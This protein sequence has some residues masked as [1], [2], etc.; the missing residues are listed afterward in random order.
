MRPGRALT[1]FAQT[2]LHTMT[3]WVRLRYR[4]G[5]LNPDGGRM[6]EE[7]FGDIDNRMKDGDYD[8]ERVTGM[9][10]KSVIHDMMRDT[11]RSLLRMKWRRERRRSTKPIFP[12]DLLAKIG[13]SDTWY[14]V[15]EEYGGA[16][17]GYTEHVIAVEELSRASGSVG[18][19]YG[20]H[21]NLCIN[22]LR[23]NGNEVQKQKYLPKLVSGEHVGSLAMSEP[24]AGSDVVSMKLRAEKKGDRYILN[25]NKFWI[26]NAPDADVLVVY[27]KTDPEA[28][29]AYR[30]HHRKGFPVQCGAEA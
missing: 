19:S 11:V 2:Y 27:A 17:M 1:V 10:L 7:I 6:R 22:Q 24:G 12:R 3:V 29:R 18:L 13:A 8:T 21:S 16:G 15:E 4:R 28:K 20:A 23:R 26:T 14:T 9:V 25:G 5:D 30:L